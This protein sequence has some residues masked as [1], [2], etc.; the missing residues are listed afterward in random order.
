MLRSKFTA[1]FARRIA[2][3]STLVASLGL[4]AAAALSAL[5]VATTG[6][7]FRQPG[8]QP[9]SLVIDIFDSGN[10]SPCHGF[11][12]VDQEPYT[13][14]AASMM[15]Q[16]GRDPIFYAGLAIANQDAANSGE[17]CLRCHTPGAWLAGRA[18]PSDGSALNPALGDLD[19]VTCHLCHRLVDPVF[20]VGNPPVDKRIHNILGADRPFISHNGNYI[21]DPQDVRRGPFDLG[22]SFFYHDWRQSPFHRESMLCGTCHD[23]SNPA[24]TRQLNGDYL[25]NTLNAE[26][27]THV[28]FDEFPIERTFSEWKNSQ[29]ARAP[30]ELGGRFGGN[31]TAVQSCQDCHM[32]KTTGTACNPILGGE[33]R[34]DLPLHDFNGANSW[35]LAAIRATYPDSETGLTAQSVADSIA[36]NV[37]M[38]T[39][40]ADLEV[41]VKSGQLVAR[42]VNQTGHKLPTGYGEGRRMWLNVQFFDA[43]N[44]LMAE[45]GAYDTGTAVLTDSDTKVYEIHHGIDANQAAVTGL[46][47]G[48]SFHFVL[49]NRIYKD[50]RVPPRG[51]TLNA[52]TSV[53]AL[54]VN[55]SFAEE[56]YWDDSAYVIPFGA[57][58]AVVSLYHQTT[59]KEYIEFLRDENT[60]NSAGLDAYNLW[61]AHGKSAPVLMQ[62]D[63]VSF[64][65]PGC[66]PPINY[67]L[68]K[69]RTNG[70]YPNVTFLGSPSV[71]ANNF[72]VVVEKAQPF[73]NVTLFTSPTQ[74]SIPYRGG[75]YLLGG[76]VTR[77]AT[78]QADVNGRVEFVF[79][80]T[81]GMINTALNFQAFFYD[82]AAVDGF[83][84]AN[85]LHVEICP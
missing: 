21:V 68:A 59:T 12:D 13:R 8:S 3:A 15:A 73:Q 53:Q 84:V 37:Q 31:I 70:E 16:A 22:P 6:L 28:P 10:C 36:R 27:P 32:P 39:R 33:V 57:D 83:G 35:V 79:P 26:H 76:S 18:T 34:T 30:V 80:L 49:N 52:F 62:T 63:T 54:P 38:L 64:A 81:G 51:F 11:Y 50:N 58:H 42:V 48:P 5:P 46:P 85:A 24:I 41:S 60:T 19:G 4:C 74:T 65:A 66:L 20:E 40:A 61:V 44:V 2:I 71:A 23:V 43:A 72:R 47:V 14:W 55:Y 69:Q 17:M 82:T 25:T 78:A 29:F 75:T 1:S 7:D 9:G 67:G 45:H 77:R 56:Q